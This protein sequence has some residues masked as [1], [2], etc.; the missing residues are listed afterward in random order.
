MEQVIREYGPRG[1]VL[2]AIN[3]EE[4]R[5]SVARWARV[6]KVTSTVLLDPTGAV[7]RAYRVTGTPTVYV[8]GRDGRLLAKALS[9]M[10]WT[11]PE[12]QAFLQALLAR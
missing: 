8:I 1:L 5:E 9:T 6:K 3:I 7:N 10:Q 11:G 12:G 4:D 2:L